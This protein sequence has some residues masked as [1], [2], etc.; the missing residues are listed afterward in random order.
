ML[1]N[2]V[3][4]MS[5]TDEKSADQAL[6]HICKF[7]K[8]KDEKILKLETEISSLKQ[9]LRYKTKENMKLSQNLEDLKNPNPLLPV[10]KKIREDIT[11]SKI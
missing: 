8:S 6:F 9:K 10:S 11:C 2:V 3:G 5:S 4:T 7:C 1:S